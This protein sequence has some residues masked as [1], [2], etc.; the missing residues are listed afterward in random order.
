M[1]HQD[2]LWRA[3]NLATENAASK[4][5]GPYGAL[6]VLNDQIISESGN[7]VTANLDP[8][9]HA[10]VMAIRAACQTL[11]S[12]QLQ[13]CVL[14]TS[15]E[16]CPM[17]LGAIYWSRLKAVYYACDRQDAANAGFDDSFIYSE[18]A[19]EPNSRKIPMWHVPLTEALKPFEAWRQLSNKVEY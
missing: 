3:V 17:C 12:F 19:V 5:G 13:D 11:Q 16:P 10:E 6:V 9:A 7:R 8:T 14:Y 18:I 2:Y 1:T 15:C 4:A